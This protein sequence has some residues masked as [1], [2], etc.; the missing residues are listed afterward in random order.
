HDERIDTTC[1]WS[2]DGSTWSEQGHDEVLLRGATI[3]GGTAND[4]AAVLWG[5][6]H[7]GSRVWVSE[8]GAAWQESALR[9]GVDL[10]AH[11]G[12]A[13]VAFGRGSNSRP[14]VA[15]STDG[16]S[17]D[18][19]RGDNPVVFEGA[20]MVVAVP[21]E[22]RFVAGGTDIMRGVAAT[23][24]TDDGRRWHRTSLPSTASTHLADLVVAGDRL[25]AVG[26]V[27]DAGRRAVEV[28][29][30]NDAASWKPVA[31]P[32]LFADATAKAMQM[33]G[34]SAVVC[35]TLYV[36]RD[37]ARVESVPVTWRSRILDSSEPSAQEVADPQAVREPEPVPAR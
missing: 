25:L 34:D 15:Y 24:A 26:V 36:E 7:H 30:S 13:F 14:T 19:S 2:D 31:T 6:S 11:L 33:V 27:R 9:G 10:V 18:E 29:E 21:F 3:E 16:L 32:E 12:D 28:W 22:G 20:R 8:D 5:R 4:D 35:G 23:W 17:W 37:D 1:W